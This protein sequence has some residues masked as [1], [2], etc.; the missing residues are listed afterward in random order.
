MTTYYKSPTIQ[1]KNVIQATGTT[2]NASS[3]VLLIGHREYFSPDT[4]LKPLTPSSGYPTVQFYH[5]FPLPLSQM[6]SPDQAMSYM[7]SL[8]F[9]VNYGLSGTVTFIDPTSATVNADL[10]VTL[11]WAT[12][13]VGYDTLIGSSVTGTVTQ[14]AATGTLKSVDSS[15]SAYAITIKNVTGTF[16]TANVVSIAYINSALSRPDPNRTEQICMMVYQAVA[17]MNLTATTFFTPTTP[18]L[19]LGLLSDRD[20]GFGPTSGDISLVK[21]DDAT[22]NLDD[23]VYLFWDAVPE[24]FAYVPLQPLG[25]ST[26]T[27]A[28]SAATGT[29][30]GVISGALN[31]GSACG[32]ALKDVTGT[33]DTTH[34]LTMVLDSTQT[35]FSLGSSYYFKYVAIPYDIETNTDITTTY[36]QFFTWLT[37]INQPVAVDSGQCGTFGVF[38]DTLIGVNSF[39]TTLPTDINSNHYVP[40]YYPY[41]PLAGEYPQPASQVA[42]AFCSFIA[43]NG[44]PYNPQSSMVIPGLLATADR[45][46][47][48]SPGATGQQEEVLLLGWNPLLI[49]ATLQVFTPRPITGQLTVP[50]FGTTPDTEFFPV[51][52]QQIVVYFVESVRA[53]W[54]AGGFQQQRQTPKALASLRQVTIGVMINF[55]NKGMFENVSNWIPLVTV[56]QDTTNPSQLN[57]TMPIQVIPE[58]ASIYGTT[59]INSSLIQFSTSIGA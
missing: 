49:A 31:P 18:Y 2:P 14:D 36:L 15:G 3:N 27:Q 11:T 25:E 12:K 1:L 24:N 39:A 20:T 45:A 47:W 57:V 44:V 22:V 42:A 40:V 35:V 32:V 54:I 7:Q 46:Q 52:T 33:F 9:T 13:P 21:P 51:S 43:A 16:D 26:I 30:V 8:G 59:Q 58:L 41:S 55:Q 4:Y 19:Y 23:T 10:S 56:V 34:A 53:A 29:I 17:A 38:A 50:G 5:P 48:L 6:G 28:T 37:T